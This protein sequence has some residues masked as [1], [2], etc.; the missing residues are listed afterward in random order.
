MNRP[1]KLPT[2]P[3]STHQLN[4]IIRK[5]HRGSFLSKPTCENANKTHANKL[6]IASEFIYYTDKPLFIPNTDSAIYREKIICF[7]AVLSGRWR[8][9]VSRQF[10]CTSDLG[11]NSS[12]HGQTGDF[13]GANKS[14]TIL[15]IT[16]SRAKVQPLSFDYRI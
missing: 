11:R 10:D 9:S 13:V 8:S 4:I 6:L 1:K 3:V 15:F 12:K 16:V 2:G 14:G 7:D 5:V